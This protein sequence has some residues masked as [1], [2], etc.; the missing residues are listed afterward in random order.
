LETRSLITLS[1]LSASSLILRCFSA[2]N[3][4]RLLT[5]PPTMK[6]SPAP[7][8]TASIT[9]TAGEAITVDNNTTLTALKPINDTAKTASVALTA[10]K[11]FL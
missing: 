9:V 10:F 11:H 1:F 7:S 2:F 4:K 3:I 8:D 6:I 5:N